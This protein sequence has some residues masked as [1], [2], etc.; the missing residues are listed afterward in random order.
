MVELSI[1]IPTRDRPTS[2]RACLAALANQRNVTGEIEVLVVDDGSVHDVKPALA[3]W[4]GGPVRLL[5]QA[6]AGPGA[7]RNR[8]AREARGRVLL[9]LDDD[10]VGESELVA[11]HQ[12]AH[13]IGDRIV[14][15]GHMTLRPTRAAGPSG[16]NLQEWWVSHYRKLAEQRDRP[17]FMDA[18][19]GSLSVA[20]AAFVEAGGFAEDLPHSEDVELG[21][22]LHALGLRFV[23]LPGAIGHQ[24]FTKGFG[25]FMAIAEASGRAGVELYR[26]H[27]AMLSAMPLGAYAQAG[28][29]ERAARR[30][31]VALPGTRALIRLVEPAI[32]RSRWR[33]RW[34]G[35]VLRA[36]YWSGVR[37]SVDPPRWAR[38]TSGTTVLLYHGFAASDEAGSR[39]VVPVRRFAAQLAWLQRRGFR[40]LDLNEWL[41]LR[42]THE[43]PPARSFVVTIDDGYEETR[44]LALPVMLQSGVPGAIFLVTGLVGQSNRWDKDPVL[45]GRPLIDWPGARQ[46]ERDGITF[47]AHSRTH[48]S[49]PGLNA[50]DVEDEVAGSR[51]DLEVQ[52]NHAISSFAYPFGDLDPDVLAAVRRAGFMTAFGTRPGVCTP[53]EPDLALRR[54]AVYGTDSLLRFAFV[55]W[56]G[57]SRWV[58]CLAAHSWRDRRRNR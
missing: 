5:R 33:R 16:R 55:M 15:L 23:Y 8:G 36:G 13:H 53:A 47:G 21:Y 7:A 12:A 42:A 31:T 50:A 3:A 37:S 18:F 24:E 56:T 46:M 44:R 48:R 51:H 26:R 20:R 9:F 17:T 39:W 45:A 14:G 1:V 38:L 32:G 25:A 22:R 29:K 35:F 43:L 34:Y 27:P 28:L 41:Q 2:L 4:P 58:R 49:L 10:V 19:T 57:D 6:N 52:L 54:V 11:G 40:P 30:L